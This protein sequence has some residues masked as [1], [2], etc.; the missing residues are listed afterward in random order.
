M[1]NINNSSYYHS[2]SANYAIQ[3]QQTRAISSR[4]AEPLTQTTSVSSENPVPSLLTYSNLGLNAKRGHTE[5]SSNGRADFSTNLPTKNPE[6][7]FSRMSAAKTLIARY[8]AIGEAEATHHRSMDKRVFEF[9]VKTREGDVVTFSIRTDILIGKGGSEASLD[10][11]TSFAFAVAGELSD[12]EL[13]AVNILVGRLGDMALSYQEDGWTDVEFLD[14]FDNG[15]LVEMDLNVSGENGEALTITYIFDADAEAHA[16]EVNQNDYEYELNA[17]NYLAQNGL[18]L[19]KNHLYLQYHQILTDTARSYKAGEFSGGVANSEAIEFFLDGLKA[20]LSPLEGEQE[21]FIGDGA[22]S[23]TKTQANNETEKSFLSGLPDF[24]A[25]F[26][27]PQFRPNASKPG[28]I[29]QMTVDMEQATDISINPGNGVKTVEQRYSY[30]SRVSQHFGIGGGSVEYAN[31]TDVNQPGGQ[32]YVYETIDKAETI[33]RTLDIDSGGV[34]VGYRE[35]K[36]IEHFVTTKEVVNGNVEDFKKDDLAV[37]RENYSFA[38]QVPPTK[39]EY[40][41][42]QIDQYR[43]IQ[44]LISALAK[45][46]VSFYS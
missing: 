3:G 35:D 28:E 37:P 9:S 34:A 27:T 10:Q 23:Q 36:D 29:S 1:I 22:A 43:D 11:E 42:A 6:N 8:R 38:L 31:L 15:E 26:N 45:S 5:I 33:K 18:S 14:V 21:E 40:R 44:L 25:S 16:L 39:P 41:A 32:T 2:A 12:E 19:E 4:H 30:E 24:S 7:N 46:H 17:E 20:I 13:A